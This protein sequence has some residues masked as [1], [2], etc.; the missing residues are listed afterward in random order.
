MSAVAPTAERPVAFVTGA[1]RGMGAETAVALARAGYDVAI[2]ARTVKEGG[3]TREANWAGTSTGQPLAGSLESVDRRVTEA[4]GKA[5]SVAMDLLD[6]GAVERAAE[7]TLDT[8]R[9]IDLVV[10]IGVYQGPGAQDTFLNTPTELFERSVMAN[11]VAPQILLS[12]FLP[13]MVEQ[14]GGIVVNMSSYVV[15]NS[16]TTAGAHGGWSVAY[17]ASKAGLDRFGSVLN[18][19]LGESGITVFTVDPGFVSYGEALAE[20]LRHY[21]DAP[22]T[23]PEAIGAAIAWLATEP[24]ARR[25]KDKRIDLTALVVK[26]ALLRGWDGP[27]SV[28]QSSGGAAFEHA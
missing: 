25:L 17:A 21:P 7:T 2:T 19:E 11:V 14:G 1:S 6:K 22:V 28:Y 13:V 9:R 27:G 26:H 23:P 10:N 3:A 8:F 18:A 16:P 24:D 12:R 15:T 4:G 20:Q 5:L